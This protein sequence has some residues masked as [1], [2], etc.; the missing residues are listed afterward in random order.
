MVYK[1]EAYVSNQHYS[2]ALN[3]Q[4][5]LSAYKQDMHAV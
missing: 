2:A 5:I 3:N 4:N 1:S